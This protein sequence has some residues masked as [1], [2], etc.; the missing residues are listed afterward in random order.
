MTQTAQTQYTKASEEARAHGDIP[1][2]TTGALTIASQAFILSS[3]MSPTLS[4]VLASSIL[5]PGLPVNSSLL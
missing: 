5:P 1:Q 3:K 4:Q 2:A